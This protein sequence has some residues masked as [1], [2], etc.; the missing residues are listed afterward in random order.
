MKPATATY[1]R[2]INVMAGSFKTY[3]VYDK[4]KMTSSTDPEINEN[5]FSAFSYSNIV[6]HSF[7]RNLYTHYDQKVKQ[8]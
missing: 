3:V 2:Y 1:C 7:T 5:N 6:N 8:Q 4:S